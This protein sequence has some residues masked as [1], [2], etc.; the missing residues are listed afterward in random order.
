MSELAIFRTL[1]MAVDDVSLQG[2]GRS[3]VL[4]LLTYGRDYTVSDDGQNSY[5][6]RWRSGAFKRMLNAGHGAG[7]PLTYE[8]DVPGAPRALPVGGS[9]RAWDDHDALMLEGRISRTSIGDDLVELLR[10]EVIRGVSIWAGVYRSTPFVGGYERS[11]GTLR[12]VAFTTVPQY[13]D[14]Q[15][16]ALRSEP[17]PIVDQSE[18][19]RMDAIKARLEALAPL[20]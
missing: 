7:V 3:V 17:P 19:P 10:D 6:E 9:Q 13:D 12:G 5:V 18:T 8:H 15:L 11:E 2:D 1:P 4:R 20:A 16:V 14:S